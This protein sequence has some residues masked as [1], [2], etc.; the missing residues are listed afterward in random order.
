MKSWHWNLNNQGIDQQRNRQKGIAVVIKLSTWA[1]LQS[2]NY[3]WDSHGDTLNGTISIMKEYQF[4]YSYINGYL[5]QCIV[6][7]YGLM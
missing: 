7:L 3:L 6:H 4:S 1:V 5:L 2:L